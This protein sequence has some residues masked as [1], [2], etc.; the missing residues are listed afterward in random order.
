MSM[1]LFMFFLMFMFKKAFD[2]VSRDKLWG[3]LQRL[4]VPLHLQ[5]AVKAMYTLI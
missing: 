3:R 4:G 2:T 5:Q 1:F